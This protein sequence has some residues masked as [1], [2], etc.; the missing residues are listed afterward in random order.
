MCDLLYQGILLGQ[1]SRLEGLSRGFKGRRI[2]AGDV[3]TGLVIL[4]AIGLA[5]WLLSA[6]MNYQERRRGRSSPIRLFLSLCKAHGLRWSQRWLL[7]RVARAHRL[8]DPAR[9]FLEP[10]RLRPDGLGPAF[11]LRGLQL[12]QL[13]DRVFGDLEDRKKP[14]DAAPPESSDSEQ[15]GTPLPPVSSQPALDVPGWIADGEPAADVPTTGS[16]GQ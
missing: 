3:V 1:Q 9:L 6:L 12:K 4:G 5:V 16:M 7:W 10:E 13:Y 11:R 14:K 8:R 15:T 2:D